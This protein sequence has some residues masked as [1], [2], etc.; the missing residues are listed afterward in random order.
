[1]RAYLLEFALYLARDYDTPVVVGGDNDFRG[2]AVRHLR[3]LVETHE[4]VLVGNI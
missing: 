1:M 2:H 3:R 4:S